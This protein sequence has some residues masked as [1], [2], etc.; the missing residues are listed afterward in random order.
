[1]LRRNSQK[2]LKNYEEANQEEEGYGE[3]MKGRR[4]LQRQE[5]YE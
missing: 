1:M 2:R 5:T 3:E 4:K